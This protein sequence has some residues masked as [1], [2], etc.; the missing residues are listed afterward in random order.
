MPPGRVWSRDRRR[1]GPIC[2]RVQLRTTRYRPA[3][4]PR[5]RRHR[6]HFFGEV[7]PRRYSPF[8]PKIS[9]T[10][11]AKVATPSRRPKT[12]MWPSRGTPMASVI[13]ARALRL[14][15]KS[16]GEGSV[17]DWTAVFVDQS[18]NAIISGEFQGAADFGAGPVASAGGVDIFV[19][20]YTQNGTLAWGRT[21][22]DAE[23]Q[24]ARSIAVGASGMRR[25]ACCCRSTRAATPGWK[26]ADPC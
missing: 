26:T 12:V 11:R 23:N 15:S 4:A 6:R 8:G 25:R 20:K 14:F 1:R 24:V 3:S 18:G 16:F 7:R 17:F 10:R 21:F 13:S 2:H 5:E 9:A 19:A 22:G